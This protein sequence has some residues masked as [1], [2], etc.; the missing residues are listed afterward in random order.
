MRIQKLLFIY[1]LLP[2]YALGQCL[3]DFTKLVPEPSADYS[4]DFGRSISMHNDFLAIGVPNSDSI[5]R[6]TGLVY[7]YKKVGTEWKK[8]AAITPAAPLNGL[9]FGWTVKLSQD[10]LFVGAYLQGGSVYV[11]RKNGADWNNFSQIAIW[12]IPDAR[13]F[14]TSQNNPIE[15]AADQNTIAITDIWHTDNTFPSGSTGAIYLYHKNISDEW[16]HSSTPSIIPPPEVEVDDFGGG[17]V[18]FQGNRMATFT[19]YAPTGIG[20]I[21][22]YKDA[23]GEFDNPMLEAKLGTTDSFGFSNSNFAFTK[24]GIFLMA[25]LDVSTSKPKYE[26]AFFEQ[27]PTGIWNDGYM[28]C[29]FDPDLDTDT[30][31]WE[32]TVFVSSGDDLIIGSRNY[33]NKGT[34]THL[35]K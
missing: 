15:I 11:F 32:P 5:G 21:Y 25:S 9:Q 23:A 8:K 33:N 7:I 13:I 29:H 35:R 22:I 16:S 18:L 20:Q 6:I 3:T 26:V 19:R 2:T 10:Y 24:D 31:N 17:G 27:P 28:T 1:Y 12:K 34:L 4:A 30:E 14:G